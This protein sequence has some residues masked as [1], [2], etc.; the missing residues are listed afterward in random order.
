MQVWIGTSGWQYRDWR[1]PFYPE[2][3]PQRD[4]LQHYAGR[5]ACVEV[6]NTFYNLPSEAAVRRWHELAPGDFRFIIKASRYLTHIRRL[7]EPEQP[8]RTMLERFEP[9]GSTMSVML[10]QLPPTLRVDVERL[11]ATLR[12]FPGWLRIAVEFRDASWFNEEVRQMLR[13][14]AAALCITDRVARTPEPDWSDLSWAYI[15]LH[16]GDGRPYPCYARATLD[17]WADRIAALRD[18]MECVH[19][20][21]NNDGRCCAPRDAALLGQ[22]CRDRRL[23]VM[24]TPEPGSVKPV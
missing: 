5:F 24:R 7:R 1:G 14:R 23:D 19:V 22:A 10:L 12:L 17:S 11:D 20:F 3:L 8:V 15:R 9:L 16:E 4:W 18:R 6:N 2:K 21:F 13:D